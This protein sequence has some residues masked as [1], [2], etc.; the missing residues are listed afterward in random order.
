MK[1][2]A[3]G[4]TI[5]NY[6]GLFAE[7]QKLEPPVIKF[8]YRTEPEDIPIAEDYIDRKGYDVQ[9]FKALALELN[10]LLICLFAP[11][12]LIDI[13]FIFGVDDTGDL[14]VISEIS[15]DCMRIKD[16]NDVSFDKDI[17]RNSADYSLLK[18]RWK[19][20]SNDISINL[21]NWVTS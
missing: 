11:Y 4:S 17:F 9:K 13:C 2:F 19:Q 18:E 8:D 6:P 10:R 21:K 12:V 16:K 7:F 3:I 14:V 15:P 1:N 20:I 5:R